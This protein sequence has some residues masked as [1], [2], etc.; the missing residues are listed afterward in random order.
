MNSEEPSCCAGEG[1]EEWEQGASAAGLV[2]DDEDGRRA[3]RGRR[4]DPF[5]EC[6]GT[7]RSSMS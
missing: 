1:R 4:T 5:E 2:P 6:L 3:A 7:W